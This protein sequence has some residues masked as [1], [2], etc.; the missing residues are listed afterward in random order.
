MTNTPKFTEDDARAFV[1]RY[2][3]SRLGPDDM[4]AMAEAMDKITAAG[5][6]V[7]RVAS[8]FDAPAPVFV[9]PQPTANTGP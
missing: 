2:S 6:A 7:T 9:V 3:F 5:L 1:K 8:K 4:T